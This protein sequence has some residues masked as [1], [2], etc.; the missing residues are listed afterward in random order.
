MLSKHEK[1]NEYFLQLQKIQRKTGSV[2]Q[3][4]HRTCFIPFSNTHRQTNF[5]R[6]YVLFPSHPFS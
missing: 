2:A 6:R 4:M 3:K 1:F 5:F